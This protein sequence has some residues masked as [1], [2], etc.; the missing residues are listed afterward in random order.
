MNSRTSRNKNS[1]IYQL[2]TFKYAWQ[3]LRYFFETE[4]KA[5]IHL[6][7]AIIAIVLGIFLKIKSAEWLM[8]SFAIGIVI[9]TEI[10]NTAIELMVDLITKE[11]NRKAGIIKDLAAS[12]VL[13]AS[14]TALTI[15]LIIYLPKILELFHTT[16]T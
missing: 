1:L 9:I 10:S 3:G 13:L 12:A 6:V 7:A 8:I 14:I 16:G 4:L 11:Q 15:G 2:T 5:S